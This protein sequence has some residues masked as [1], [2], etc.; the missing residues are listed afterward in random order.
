MIFI[1]LLPSQGYK[2]VLSVICM[3]SHWVETF[4]CQP[5]TTSAVTKQ[6]LE[7][8]IPTW[9]IPLELHSA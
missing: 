1:Q 3:F 4:P 6:L 9:G 7:K 5:A 8:I 2:Y